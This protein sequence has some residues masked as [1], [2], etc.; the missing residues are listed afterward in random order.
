MN[1]NTL[2]FSACFFKQIYVSLHFNYNFTTSVRTY[3]CVYLE[4]WGLPHSL[5]TEKHSFVL[6]LAVC[7]GAQQDCKVDHCTL[8]WKSKDL[9]VI[10]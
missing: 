7:V 4:L 10:S 1:L 6:W 5:R 2:K 8:R 9:F 3:I